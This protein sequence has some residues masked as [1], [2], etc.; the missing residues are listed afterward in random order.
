VTDCA[1][2]SI[3][4]PPYEAFPYILADSGYDV[5][6]G[7]NRGNGVSMTYKY[8]TND[9]DKF[10]DFTWD[11]MAKYDLPAQVNF[12]LKF[13]NKTKLSIAGHSQ[14]TVQ[15]FAGLIINPALADKLNIYIAFAP[16]AYVH[17][18]GD[19]LIRYLADL[20][21]EFLYFILGKKAFKVGPI[22]HDILPGFCKLFPN[23]CTQDVD[24]ICGP[25]EYWNAT[26]V[27]FYLDYEPNPT[28]VKDMIH[29]VQ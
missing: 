6:L 1:A 15:I 10:W 25:T 26:R 9:E 5:W 28:S 7:N 24:S 4:N 27:P 23:S 11:E 3:L 18:V 14:G 19:I 16:I 8:A 2:G 22:I 21:D 29:W 17:N 12:I 20:P 13:T